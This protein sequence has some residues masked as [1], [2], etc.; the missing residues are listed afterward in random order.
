MALDRDA[1]FT[2]LKDSKRI[3]KQLLIDEPYLRDYEW[4]E[5]SAGAGSFLYAVEDEGI[6]IQGYDIHPMHEDV[7]END[8][9]ED[10]LDLTGKVV[11]GNPPYGPRQ[12]LTLEFIDKSFEYGAEYVGFL[13]LGSFATYSN[14]SRIKSNCEIVAIR[15]YNVIFE[16]DQGKKVFSGILKYP[17]NFILLKRSNKR[18]K[19]LEIPNI[20]SRS[21]NPYDAD[22]VCGHKFFRTRENLP[23][24]HPD[25][26]KSNTAF[27]LKNHKRIKQVFFYNC[28]DKYNVELINYLQQSILNGDPTPR[29]LNF[30]TKYIHVLKDL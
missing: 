2:P 18:L 19:D 11:I 14:F 25:I 21:I 10:D 9:L 6:K 27:Y 23:E 8:F 1:Y 16:D 17:M 12:K 5:P 13:L 22:F 4:V 15:K 29:T 7:I 30:Y 28:T 20:Y 3:I 24:V 26:I